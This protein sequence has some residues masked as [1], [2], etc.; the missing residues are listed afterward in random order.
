M[1]LPSTTTDDPC[2]GISNTAHFVIKKTQTTFSH[3][4]HTSLSKG[5]FEYG[6]KSDRKNIWWTEEI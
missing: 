1:G 2:H 4:T 5:F 3:I 6:P